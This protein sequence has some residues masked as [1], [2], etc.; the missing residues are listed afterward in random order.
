MKTVR[1]LASV[2]VQ[3]VLNLLLLLTQHY[4]IVFVTF[5]VRKQFLFLSFHTNEKCEKIKTEIVYA[6]RM[7]HHS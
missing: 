1:L 7:L 5:D 4:Y 6:H 2:A 3:L